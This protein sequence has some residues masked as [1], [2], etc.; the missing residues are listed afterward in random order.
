MNY[1]FWEVPFIGGG[2]VIA[3][4]A[5]LHVFVSHFAVG[6]GFF[7][8]L[9]ER[10]ALKENDNALLA[11][12]KSHSKFFLLLTVVFG[13]VSGVGI[14]FA[15]GLVHP[16]ATSLL[17]HTFVWFW[18]IEWTFFLVEV[19]AILIYYSTWDRLDPRT[20]NI[21]GWI[22]FASAYL[23]LVVIN[24]I[25]TFML[26]PGG[27]LENK[28]VLS[29]WFNPS[30]LPSL[31]I[32][33]GVA[34][35]LAGMYATFTASGLFFQ[36]V[37]KKVIRYS[38][39]WIML[40]APLILL[41]GIWYNL[42]IPRRSVELVTGQAPPLSIFAASTIVLSAIIF[43]FAY[44]I[45]CR[46]PDTFSR[47]LALL[48]LVLGLLVT[49]VTEWTREAVRKPYIVHGYMYS[50]SI[51]PDALPRIQ[52]KPILNRAIWVA[53]RQAF[54]WNYEDAGKEIFRVQCNICHTVIGYNGIKPLIS[55]WTEQDIY[56]TLGKLDRIKGY[57]PPFVGTEEERRAL[58]R[59]LNTLNE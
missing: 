4:I 25:L 7:L 12:V 55:G 52:N 56:D 30:M 24:G 27:W 16:D 22:Y 50:N 44:F 58:A 57:M 40:G 38:C 14:W 42:V 15:I 41:G 59:W 33:T 29:A 9:T 47:P 49:G 21:I 10:K 23:S 54:P 6:G 17:I 46:H 26:T 43:A 45:G 53:H 18:A 8:A 34:L 13:A 37:K 1:P 48:F 5:I 3:V 28:S 31:V 19:A 51:L 32:R 35:A 11:Y 39:K 20:H 2:L 36:E